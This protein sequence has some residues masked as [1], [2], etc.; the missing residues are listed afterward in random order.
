MV[1]TF[2]TTLYTLFTL[3]RSYRCSSVFCIN[4]NSIRINISAHLKNVSRLFHT[5][6]RCGRV[7]W[8]SNWMI[9]GGQVGIVFTHDR[10]TPNAALFS[11]SKGSNSELVLTYVGTSSSFS[12]EDT[13]VVLMVQVGGIQW[14][15]DIEIF[16][17][18]L[19][20][21][22]RLHINKSSAKSPELP[23]TPHFQ[24]TEQRPDALVSTIPLVVTVS[25]VT[26]TTTTPEG[27]CDNELERKYF[28]SM[29]V[30]GACL[31][32]LLTALFLILLCLCC[33]RWV[34]FE[35]DWHSSSYFS[36]GYAAFAVD[37]AQLILLHRRQTCQWDSQAWWPK[38]LL[39]D[40]SRTQ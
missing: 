27:A 29:V 20:I 23:N 10:F 39:L 26:T 1:S 19:G 38:E 35:K 2:D 5:L 30:L 8:E 24:A 12:S 31:G 6:A 9:S 15:S 13:Q 32:G 33:K 11:T 28:I 22:W 40:H 4:Q 14:H 37:L 16:W 7:S 34:S 36:E 21:L 3:D 18:Y 25:G 17:K